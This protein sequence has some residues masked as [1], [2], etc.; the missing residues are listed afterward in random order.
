MTMDPNFGGGQGGSGSVEDEFS[1]GFSS[2]AYNAL[3]RQAP[4]LVKDVI[5]FRILETDP[6]NGMGVGTFILNH[7]NE[8]FFVP[9]VV[10]DN[11][12]KPLD[13]FYSR[14]LDRYYPLTPSWL[15]EASRSAI[16][17]MGVGVKAP[18]TLQTD[19]DIRNLVVPPTTGRYSYASE[20]AWCAFT[21]LTEKK[22]ATPL[23]LMDALANS[24]NAVKLGFARV[25]H[26]NPKI[27][28]KMAQFYGK[29]A[30][31]AAL[32]PREEKVAESRK[33][34]PMKH[35]VFAVNG[36]APLQTLKENLEPGEVAKAFS[37]Q[38]LF[39]FY[40]KDRRKSTKN[41]LHETSESDLRLIEPTENGLYTVWLADGTPEEALILTLV[42][43]TSGVWG[44]M[45]MPFQHRPEKRFFVFLKDGKTVTTKHLV[46]SPV[47]SE[48]KDAADKKIKALSKKPTNGARGFFVSTGGGT[49]RVIEPGYIT[50]VS[51]RDGVLSCDSNGLHIRMDDKLKPAHAMLRP[52]GN[53][54]ITLGCG[55]VFVPCEDEYVS[56]VHLAKDPSDVLRVID[57]KLVSS[58]AT[59]VEVKTGYDRS[60]YVGSSRQPLSV[61]KAVAKIAMDYDL[62]VNDAV[63]ALRAVADLKNVR[64][65][66]VKKAADESA[67][68]GDPGMDPAAMDPNAM[69]AMQAPPPPSGLDLAI[70]EQM[71][72]IQMQIQAL[73]D[74]AT[75]LQMVQQRAMQI[76]GGGG[77]M[78]APM[79]A[80]AMAGGPAAPVAGM[81]A[82][83]P[84]SQMMQPLP[85]PGQ[86][87][88]MQ[89]GQAPMPQPGAAQQ[90]GPA[91]MPPAQYGDPNAAAMQQQ[92]PP[93]AT[94]TNQSL[95]A[96]DVE[97]SINPG[98]LEMAGELENA[99][100]F[101][102]AAVASLAKQKQLRGPMLSYTANLDKSLD[103]LGR[104]LLLLNLREAE[105]KETI[106]ND[107]Y[108]NS[109][110]VIR[111]TFKGLG[112]VILNAS[113]LTD[114]VNPSSNIRS[115]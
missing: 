98:F 76:D 32:T 13:L 24:E 4:D 43:S 91:G 103:N 63:S 48:S 83:D 81:P 65:W 12:I 52:P 92:P 99:N 60:I 25:L 75:A 36:S 50:K 49:A 100:V 115:A 109:E 80:A 73:N 59:P 70:A 11:A 66:A 51:E 38:R 58:G 74:K 108:L 30:I 93:Q 97:S 84:N 110:Q 29:T 67:P 95:S 85:M 41:S 44:G 2:M 94:M 31:A 107:A 53:N 86:P 40:V 18:P 21:S 57:R 113:Q 7:D 101:D 89:Q 28:E 82:Q 42:N 64:L 55:W 102:A 23:Q 79:G 37:S 114:Q 26:K 56:T 111:D 10:V 96:G 69:A 62:S 106:G 71:Q 112:E 88:Q 27:L 104:L 33:E 15:Q 46:A 72:Q 61:E 39:G 9:V 6:D 90:M 3:T 1:A 78:A 5:T 8:V 47:V 54:T 105:L 17:E 34:I 35:D 16:G 19:V 77:A 22:A 87:G 68:E 14:R 45:D 20:D